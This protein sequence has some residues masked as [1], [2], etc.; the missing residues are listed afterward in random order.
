MGLGLVPTCLVDHELARGEV[1]TPLAGERGRLTSDTGYFLCYP[2]NKAN[3]EPLAL[4]RAWLQQQCGAAAAP[5]G[6]P[7]P[8]AS[9]RR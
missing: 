5:V 3:T 7:A 9:T 8:G 4:F 6:L 1:I 2:E